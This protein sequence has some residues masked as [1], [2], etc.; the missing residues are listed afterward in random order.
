MELEWVAM[1][2]LIVFI[3]AGAAPRLRKGKI[4]VWFPFFFTLL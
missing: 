1:N 2:T 4:S 3:F